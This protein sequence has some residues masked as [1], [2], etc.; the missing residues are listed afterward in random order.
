MLTNVVKQEYVGYIK[1]RFQL[2]NGMLYLTSDR[3]IME[4]SPVAESETALA[5]FNR[6]K[7]KKEIKFDI[8]RGDIQKIEKGRHGLNRNVL[9]I[10]D[11]TGQVWKFI[12]K[13]YEEWESE[14]LHRA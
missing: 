3:L 6:S 9:E 7:E 10:T 2:W 11:L 12:V 5:L 4:A 13:N 8:A 1:S 14:L